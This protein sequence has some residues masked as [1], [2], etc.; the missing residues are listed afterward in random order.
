MQVEQLFNLKDKVVL[1]TGAGGLLGSVY[2][3]YFLL[4]GSKVVAIDLI[5]K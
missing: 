3:N 4:N 5:T 1:I 2:S